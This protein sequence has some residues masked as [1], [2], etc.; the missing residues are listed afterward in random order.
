MTT[1][2]SLRQ[3]KNDFLNNTAL[4]VCCPFNQPLTEEN[5]VFSG[6]KTYYERVHTKTTF[7]RCPCCVCGIRST[8]FKY[9]WF[10]GVYMLLIRT[11]IIHTHLLTNI[12]CFRR[13]IW[14]KTRSVYLTCQRYTILNWCEKFY[15]NRTTRWD[16]LK[17]PFLRIS[18]LVHTYILT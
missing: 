2:H 12:E 10:G 14:K 7:R 8:L 6:H 13:V 18:Y 16:I 1:I 9:N 11:I 5:D 17:Y 3:R 4:L 15:N